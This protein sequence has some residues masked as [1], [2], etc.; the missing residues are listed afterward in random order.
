[1]ILHCHAKQCDPRQIAKA[2][3]IP[4][5]D[6]SRVA[7]HDDFETDV[8]KRMHRIRAENEARRRIT[9]EYA[10]ESYT[11]PAPGR[12]LADDLAVPPRKRK[13]TI[14]ELHTVGGNSLLVAQYKTGKTTL[15]LNLVQALADH[16]PFLG[17]FDV[18][19]LDGRIAFWNY[20][21]DPD[22]FRTWARD[23]GIEHPE[24]VAEPFHLRGASL[25]IWR[26]SVAD[27]VV[28]WLRSNEVQ[29]LIVDPAAQAWNGL[30][31]TENDNTD[32]G[33]FLH[34]LDEIKRR[35]EVPDL[36][37]AT[38]MGRGHAD[39]DNE[40]SRGATRLED[41]MDAG[42]YLT[43]EKKTDTRTLRARVVM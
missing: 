30:V 13:Y 23:I 26:P 24:H 14:D 17:H 4:F 29:F 32:V 31:E 15:L 21:L 9:S 37:L 25:P 7:D 34:I 1:M 8:Q 6:L 5:A 27:Q 10:G 2:L 42:W 16:K 20:E 40:R 3:S 22:M 11:L 12:T 39:E 18:A 19:A 36:V 28:D 43:K 35:A 38:H 41:W 33:G